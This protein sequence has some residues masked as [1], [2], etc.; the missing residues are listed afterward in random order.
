MEIGTTVKIEAAHRLSFYEGK[1]NRMHGH[2]WQV[3]IR[4]QSNIVE[5]GKQEMVLDFT[6]M[7]RIVNE[8]DHKVILQDNSSNRSIAESLPNNW[9]VWL[10]IEPTAENLSLYLKQEFEK[11][12]AET[13]SGIFFDV[14]VTVWESDVSYATA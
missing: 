11:I 9:I 14:L 6:E 8:L 5:Q 3:D 7:K 4:I 12:L 1:C 13:H 10:E 2:N